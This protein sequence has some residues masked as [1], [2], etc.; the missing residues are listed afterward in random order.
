MINVQPQ[1]SQIN[2]GNW[3]SIEN[4][5]KLLASKKQSDLLVYTGTYGHFNARDFNDKNIVDPKPLYMYYENYKN[6]QTGKTELRQEFPVPAYLW[7]IAMVCKKDGSTENSCDF[8]QAEGIAIITSNNPYVKINQRN[9][10]R[11]PIAIKELS[12]KPEEGLSYACQVK[13]FLDSTG[14]QVKHIGKNMKIKLLPY[15]V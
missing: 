2:A 7:K 6:K 12:N 4:H 10:C 5:I 9:L 3:L 8:G 1:W 14:I 15:T 11:L 13:D